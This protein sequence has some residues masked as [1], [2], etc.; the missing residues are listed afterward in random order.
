M[1]HEIIAQDPEQLA[2]HGGTRARLRGSRCTVCDT[3]FFPHRW[4][5]AIDQAACVD[6]ELSTEGTVH[7]AT[8]VHK[9]SYGKQAVDTAGYAVGQI[10]LPEGPRIQATLVGGPEITWERGDRVHLTTESLGTDS[11]GRT[12]LAYRFAAGAADA[13]APQ[14]GWMASDAASRWHDRV[15]TILQDRQLTFGELS[16]WVDTMAASFVENGVGRGDRVL[17]HLPNGY[18]VLVFQLAAWRIGA[19]AVPVIPIYRQRELDYI[20]ATVTPKVVVTVASLPDRTP[21][22]EFDEILATAGVDGTV[23][24][25][26]GGSADGWIAAPASAPDGVELAALPEPA[27]PDDTCL[28]LF[29]SGTTSSPKGAQLTSR[30]LVK[31]TSAWVEIGIGYDDVALAIAPLAHI[32]GLIAGGLVPLTVG[33]RAVILTRWDPD[34]AVVLIDQHE[35]TFSCGATVFLQDLVDRYEKAPASLHRLSHFISGGAATP[36]ALIHRAEAAGMKASR[37]YG[38]TE[39]AGV[40]T[41]SSPNAPLERRAE[42]DGRLVPGVD[43]KI[44]DEAGNEL[45]RGKEG[46]LLIKGEQVMLGYT[47]KIVTA[48]QL[49]DGWFNPGDLGLLTDDN[50][51]KITGR[52]KDIVN[53]G[54]E[55][56]SS[57]DIEEAILAHHTVARVAVTA[58]PHE[59]FGEVV[60][61]WIVLQPDSTWEGPDELVTHLLGLGM[62]KA[63]LPAHWTVIEQLPMTTSGKVQKHML[64]LESSEND[65]K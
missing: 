13:P 54:G 63:K 49:Q 21:P 22:S 62:A 8:Y 51:L 35:A 39:T 56:F 4:E 10:D 42:Y 16:R 59:R 6:V 11:D 17:V 60:G 33:C 27:G 55:K 57:R 43:V 34:H 1:S 15:F 32:A 50:W 52:T 2:V 41:L 58:V 12:V 53:R 5:C 29:T 44:V 19:I 45:P 20:V 25:L 3:Y 9:P 65:H 23:K 46:S 7:V 61:A 36:P 64:R 24:Y 38:G 37:A 18:E 47:D 48:E 14:V 26:V 31:A 30:S 40:I 28:I